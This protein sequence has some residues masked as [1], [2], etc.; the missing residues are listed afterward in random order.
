MH[1]RADVEAPR[2]RIW[3]ENTDANVASRAGGVLELLQACRSPCWGDSEEG[4][5]LRQALG[6]CLLDAN[7]DR[8]SE[9]TVSGAWVDVDLRD[10][11]TAGQGDGA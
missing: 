7:V 2:P 3:R 5:G 4:D 11:V 8:S 9:T 10:V 6:R 1:H